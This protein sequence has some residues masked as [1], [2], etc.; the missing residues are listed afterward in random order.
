MTHTISRFFLYG[1]ILLAIVFIA[2]EMNA[3]TRNVYA[4]APSGLPAMVATTSNPGIGPT[5]LTLFATSTNCAA[6][7]IT[8]YANPAM[9]TFSDYAGQTPTA[10]FGHLQLA[11]TTVVYDSG[12]YG[13]G[14]V[15]AYGYTATTSITVSES[16]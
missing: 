7:V 3:V 2:Y 16:R 13:C 4:G 10:T 5:A 6:R 12:Q 1:A 11:S 9:F 15:K 14:L 8:T